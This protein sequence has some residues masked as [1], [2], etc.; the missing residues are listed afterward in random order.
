MNFYFYVIHVFLPSTASFQIPVYIRAA[1]LEAAKTVA[2]EL[3]CNLKKQFELLMP[4][5]DPIRV[6]SGRNEPQFD[7]FVSQ[8]TAGKSVTIN[9]PPKF[10]GDLFQLDK[11]GSRLDS[12]MARVI[13][14]GHESEYY[15][16]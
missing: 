13:V 14:P 1:H 7:A 15:S 11:S 12:V 16:L 9:L 5:S 6:I 4:P 3:E 8:I 2:D 10:T